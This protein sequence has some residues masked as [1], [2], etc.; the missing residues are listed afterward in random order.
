MSDVDLAGPQTAHSYAY[1]RLRAQILSGALTPGTPLVQSNLARDFGVSMTP[2]REAL[3]D[4]ST[5]GLVTLVAHRG[6]VVT[7]LDLQD[8]LE[9]HAIRLVLEPDAVA[10]AVE[11][12]T[13]DVARQAEEMHVAMASASAEAWVVLNRD[14]HSLLLST[15]P[16]RRLR[17]LLQSLLEA[18]ALY[19]GVSINHR[20]GAPNVEHRQL[21]DAYRTRDADKAR[22]IMTDHITGSINSL[23]EIARTRG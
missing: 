16:S 7:S 19:V 23:E 21:L 10:T 9:L 20:H 22:A 6:A 3:R 14:F 17:S 11:N 15:L 13:D 4:L 12:G 18:A 8:A 1:K 5:E 2:V